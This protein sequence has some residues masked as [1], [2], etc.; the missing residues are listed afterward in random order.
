MI[1]SSSRRVQSAD[2]IIGEKKMNYDLPE[3]LEIKEE[4]EEEEEEE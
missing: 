3:N 2:N 1:I 4:E